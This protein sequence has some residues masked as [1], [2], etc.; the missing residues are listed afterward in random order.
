MRAPT[1]V[2]ALSSLLVGAAQA[3]AQAVTVLMKSGQRVAGD[4]ASFDQSTVDVRQGSNR[5][6]VQWNDIV[7]LDFV[8]GATQLP[9]TELDAARRAAQTVVL[10]GG[11]SMQGRVVD[12]VRE[13]GANAALVFAPEGQGQREIPIEQVGRLYVSPFSSDALAATGLDAI[14]QPTSP[15]NPGTPLPP[16]SVAV[17]VPSTTRWVPTGVSVARGQ[18]VTFDSDGVIYLRRDSQEEAKAAGAVSGATAPVGAPLPGLLAGALVGRI[19]TGQP[20]GIG[21]QSSV[22]MPAAGELFLGVNDDEL[23]D[24]QGS[25]SVRITRGATPRRR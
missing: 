19:G 1:L 18:Q 15:S 2:F 7:L 16:G 23:S 25:F 8:G 3:Q 11:V 12:F 4:L 14:T 21:N 20:F 9:A 10:K 24:N 13:G 22:S 6:T 5:R 17:V